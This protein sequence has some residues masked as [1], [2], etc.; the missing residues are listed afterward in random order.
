MR[1]RSAAKW[2]CRRIYVNGHSKGMITPRADLSES[3]TIE[4][5]ATHYFDFILNIIRFDLVLRPPGDTR[6][7]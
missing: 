2:I 3:I 6:Q 4:S 1:N 5:V 7:L